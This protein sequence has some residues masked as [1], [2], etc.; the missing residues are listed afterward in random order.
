MIRYGKDTCGICEFINKSIFIIF[1]L[2]QTELYA[3]I[4]YLSDHRGI[5][6]LYSNV[7]KFATWT[8]FLM[9]FQI[10][11]FDIDLAYLQKYV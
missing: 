10:Y 6:F 8:S 3:E 4:W 7:I 5:T 2:I 11:W 1:V 9:V